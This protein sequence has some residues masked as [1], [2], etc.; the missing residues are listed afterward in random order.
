MTIDQAI[1]WVD[2]TQNN[3]AS[4]EEKIG[5]L[6]QLDEEIY[7]EVIRK[8]EGWEDVA[9][10]DYTAETPGDR[11]LLVDGQYGSI[12]LHFLQSRIDYANGEYGRYNNSNMQFEADR[13]GFR[14]WYNREHMPIQPGRRL[15]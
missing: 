5:W 3:T 15:L 1:E 10:P 8:H 4:R 2:A 14:C 12:Y 6:R 7:H 11:G 9:E 13:L